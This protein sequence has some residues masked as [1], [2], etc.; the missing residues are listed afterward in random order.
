[1]HHPD[2][3][4]ARSAPAPAPAD[5]AELRGLPSAVWRFGQD[6]R[7]ALLRRLVDVT[8]GAA[9][10]LGCGLGVYTAR[11]TAAGAT[12]VGTEIEWPRAVEARRRGIDV[13]AAVGEALPFADGT[14]RAILSH[15]VL[16]HVRDDRA[17]VAEAVRTL[18][19]GGRLIVF[20]PNRLW[21]F[22]THGIVWRGRYHFGNIPLVNVLPDT[23]RNRLAPHVRVYTRRSLRALF[24]ADG[25]EATVR[26]VHHGCVFPG[27]DNLAARR[28]LLGR[29]ARAATYGLERTPARWLGLSHVIVVERRADG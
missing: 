7:F 27:Y 12:A 13:V 4:A 18:A 16:E 23:L 24:A 9:L 8:G 22:E 25:P 11:M 2:A 21:P 26:I 14:F 19:P 17:T 5:A 1:M 15:E 20:V 6:R 3:S 28:P 29:L 10:D